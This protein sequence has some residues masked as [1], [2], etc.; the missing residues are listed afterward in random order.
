MINFILHIDHFLEIS[1]DYVY[2]WPVLIEQSHILMNQ[3]EN[4]IKAADD[5]VKSWKWDDEIVD[6]ETK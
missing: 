5:M 3:I 6:D 2:V 1:F 4:Q